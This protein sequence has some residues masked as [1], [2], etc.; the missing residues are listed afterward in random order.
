MPTV[1]VQLGKHLTLTAHVRIARFIASCDRARN[2]GERADIEEPDYNTA[3]Q[4]ADL[5]AG[6]TEDAIAIDDETLTIEPDY[7]VDC[8]DDYVTPPYSDVNVI[9]TADELFANTDEQMQL[10]NTDEQLQLTDEDNQERRKI[11]HDVLEAVLDALDDFSTSQEHFMRV[12]SYGRDLYC[13]GD[14]Q[15]LRYWPRSW[16]AV[17]KLLKMKGYKEP[18]TYQIC[19]STEHPTCYEIMNS[20]ELV[21]K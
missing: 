18:I 7:I 12:L 10:A 14:P 13:K 16:Q 6:Q 2:I 11:E 9:S 15:L 5:P 4:I 20:T 3:L 21:C 1:R 19:L 17:T 8:A